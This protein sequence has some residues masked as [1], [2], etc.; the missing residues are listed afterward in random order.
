MRQ[1]DGGYAGPCQVI[2]MGAI[3]HRPAVK[4]SKCFLSLCSQAHLHELSEIL[5]V[6]IIDRDDE[7]PTHEL[8]LLYAVIVANAPPP[9]LLLSAPTRLKA[10]Q[11]EQHSPGIVCGQMHLKNRPQI[12]SIITTVLYTTQT[13]AL[14]ST[15]FPGRKNSRVSEH[16]VIKLELATDTG[17]TESN[18]P[19]TALF[20]VFW[21]QPPKLFS[22][23]GDTVIDSHTGQ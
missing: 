20:T 6:E 16:S 21:T 14:V 18:V 10:L 11:E 9:V 4:F 19:A 23:L 5:H 7:T 8:G 2:C 12:I 13:A 17:A 15:L 3:P 1:N 22:Y